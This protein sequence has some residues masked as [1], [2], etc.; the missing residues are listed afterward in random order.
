MAMIERFEAITLAAEPKRVIVVMASDYDAM[1]TRWL[2]QVDIN[3]RL[4][5]MLA[6]SSDIH[7]AGCEQESGDPY[8]NC[9]AMHERLL[10][11]SR[12]TGLRCRC[13]RPAFFAVD[14]PTPYCPSCEYQP[15]ATCDCVSPTATAEL[16]PLP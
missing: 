12:R 5:G 11:E 7:R 1:V 13:G 3:D 10:A 6:S 8:C 15:C 9:R 4:R 16:E 14:D 2:R